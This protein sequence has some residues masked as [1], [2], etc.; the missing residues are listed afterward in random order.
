MGKLALLASG[1]KDQPARYFM[2]M[3]R[4]TLDNIPTLPL[5]CDGIEVRRGTMAEAWRQIWEACTGSVSGSLGRN[6][7]G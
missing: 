6:R 2:M 4:P 7:M 3:V 5:A 1:Y